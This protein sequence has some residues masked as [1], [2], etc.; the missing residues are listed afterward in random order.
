MSNDTACSLELQA[1]TTVEMHQQ[2]GLS[3]TI[4]QAADLPIVKG[5]YELP[6][7]EG[8]DKGSAAALQSAL[9]SQ[10]LQEQRHQKQGACDASHQT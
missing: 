7:Q 8:Y 6:Q 3:R 2:A 5:G 4:F 1:V 10:V 9:L